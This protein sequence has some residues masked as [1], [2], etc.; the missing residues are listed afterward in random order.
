MRM[1]SQQ[2]DVEFIVH[3]TKTDF[4]PVQLVR[5]TRVQVSERE[6]IPFAEEL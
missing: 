6:M 4:T 3:E 1:L 5:A 2:H